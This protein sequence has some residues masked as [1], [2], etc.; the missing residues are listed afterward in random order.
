M[1]PNPENEYYEDVLP[2][3]EMHNFLFNRTLFDTERIPQS[4][5]PQYGESYPES[6]TSSQSVAAE[7]QISPIDNPDLLVL[8]N[9]STLQT[10]DLPLKVSIVF[11]KK[12]PVFGEPYEKE[13][14]LRCYQPGDMIVGFVTVE[15]TCNEIIPFEMLLVSLEGTMTAPQSPNSTCSKYHRQT[16][17]RTYD[18]SACFHHGC[19]NP[20]PYKMGECLS[21][22]PVDDTLYGFGDLKQIFP[23]AKHK[24]CFAFRLPSYLLET[25]CSSGTLD[26]LPVPPSFGVSPFAL[27]GKAMD[28]RVNEALGYGR[29]D[30]QGSPIVTNDLGD[31]GL[32]ITYSVNLRLL[33]RPQELYKRFYKRHTTHDYQF[34]IVRDFSVPF[35]FTNTNIPACYDG[36]SAEKQLDKIEHQVA[37]LLVDFEERGGLI[38]AGIIDTEEQDQLL[39]AQ[40]A[41]KKKCLDSLGDPTSNIPSKIRLGKGFLK[42]DAELD[43]DIQSA[44]GMALSSFEPAPLKRVALACVKRSTG[45]L[46]QY[47]PF[48]TSNT[49]SIFEDVSVS[50]AP[51]EL[52]TEL[53][54]IEFVL[55]TNDNALVLPQDIT[56]K[57]GLRAFNIYSGHHLP[58]VF[59]ENTTCRF[60]DT[61][62]FF[63]I[64]RKFE[65]YLWELKRLAKRT[66][67][68]ISKHLYESLLSLNKMRCK[69][70]TLDVFEVQRIRL[71]WEKTKEGFVANVK[72]PL[73]YE[74]RKTRN[75]HLIPSFQTCFLARQYVLELKIGKNK[76]LGIPIRVA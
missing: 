52:N 40:G 12:Y 37:E 66:N 69:G 71:K 8:N 64:N 74:S 63:K 51:T 19:I 48:T 31:K 6:T 41:D 46:P 58:L 61:G 33:G 25:S 35:R 18:L 30:E 59:N 60:Y 49:S 62:S 47:R 3:F 29:A 38:E 42:T 75:V 39:V 10:I 16:F 24:K 1:S 5:L 53:T 54:H 57:P 27:G 50:T 15:N 20:T 65:T 17:L 45:Q 4:G 7:N 9:L 13:S 22:D 28:I 44:D 55:K 56:V 76:P 36:G 34:I 32:S 67:R 26:H 70:N 73:I 21:R 23:G 43:I 72:V 14:P 11:T 2:S 68:P